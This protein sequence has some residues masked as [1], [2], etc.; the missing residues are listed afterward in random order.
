M[1]RPLSVLVVEDSEDDELLLLM[2][3]RQAGFDPTW[4]R[5][6]TPGAMAEALDGDAFELVISDHNMPSF[7]APQ[8]LKLLRDRGFDQPF[9]I[10]SGSIGEEAAVAAMKA[11]AQDYIVKGHL[12]RLPAAIERELKDAQERRA[13]REAEEKIRFL[14]F[15]DP[16]TSLPNRTSF[17]EQ[18]SKLLRDH[19]Q[20]GEP[21]AVLGIKLDNLREINNTLGFDT[22][23]QVLSEL[24]RRLRESINQPQLLARVGGAEFAVALPDGDLDSGMNVAR[25]LQQAIS[26]AVSVGEMEV[27]T[28]TSIGVAVFP[29][30]GEVPELLL[31]R[32]NVALTQAIEG[33][34]RIAIYDRECDPY[35]PQ[36]LSMISE[37]RRGIESGQLKLQYQP[38][39]RFD[40]GE[41]V[42]V[43]ALVR[44]LHPK[45]GQISPDQ[46]IPLAEKTG[47]INPLTRWVLKE[48]MRQS[49]AWQRSG[50][51]LNIAVNL[52]AKNLQ[53]S[54]L[55]EH[56]GRLLSASGIHP[57][58]LV[59]EVTESAIMSDEP[60]AQEILR[61]LH[62]QGIE[63]AIDDFGT[64]YS[65]FAN[66]RRLPVS[67]IKIDKSFVMGMSASNEDRIIVDSIIELGHK[68][69]LHVVAEGVETHSTWTALG[70]LH[71]DLA[72]GYFLSRPLPANDVLQWTR[73]FVGPR[74][75][76]A[77]SH[78]GVPVT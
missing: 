26:G 18:L 64:G 60:R 77:G 23:E 22:G 4:R 32:T 71:C 24:G 53:S 13:R 47:L 9:I 2:C 7:S 39:V 19:E 70:D 14:A 48:A 58:R 40:T 35:Q 75:D 68:L 29:G 31:Q 55:T 78:S 15:Y 46:F 56:L 44:W 33:P 12:G 63:I 36:R 20:E 52:S 50:L 27:D 11:G 28:I 65:S 25:K 1:G 49:Y 5:V 38:K 34:S 45:L 54:D 59:L 62:A 57:E 43:E 69:G 42:G 30:H 41:L 8:A 10:V 51:D 37:L 3:L 6:D 16:L 74:A 17:C 66:L 76:R 61:K 67:E 72:Q 21:L 73:A